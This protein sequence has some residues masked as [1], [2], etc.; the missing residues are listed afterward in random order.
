MS[1]SQLYFKLWTNR[2]DLI[3][4][5]FNLW[6]LFH[7]FCATSKLYWNKSIIKNNYLNQTCHMSHSSGG[8]IM[9]WCIF[10]IIQISYQCPSLLR[11]DIAFTDH[12]IIIIII[13]R[14]HSFHIQVVDPGLFPPSTIIWMKVLFLSE[15]K[16]NCSCINKPSIGLLYH[17][18]SCMILWEKCIRVW[19]CLCHLA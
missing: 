7:H 8:N 15:W 12:I 5:R 4:L 11:E 19:V 2:F 16:H 18:S 1:H 10:T 3:S 9:K 17:Q 13:V 14:G 6:I